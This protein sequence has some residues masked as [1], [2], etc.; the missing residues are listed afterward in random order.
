VLEGLHHGLAGV[1]RRDVLAR[2]PLG[3]LPAADLARPDAVPRLAQARERL[4]PAGERRLP[5]VLLLDPALDAVAVLAHLV[6]DDELRVRIPAEHLL[7][8][9]HLLLAE[10]RAVR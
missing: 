1:A 2:L 5:L 4:R 7:R 8:G 9:A 3:Q 6:R 10:R